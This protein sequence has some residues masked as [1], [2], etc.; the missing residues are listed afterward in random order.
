MSKGSLAVFGTDSDVEKDDEARR[1]PLTFCFFRPTPATRLLVSRG[2]LVLTR[3]NLTDLNLP[4]E[5]G[6][7]RWVSWRM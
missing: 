2:T 7:E 3:R 1:R 6:N 4:T 5:L